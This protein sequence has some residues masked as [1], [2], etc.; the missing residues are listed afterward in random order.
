VSSPLANTAPPAGRHVLSSVPGHG[1]SDLSGAL[2]RHRQR[3]AG[4]TEPQGGYPT[5]AGNN[6]DAPAD[7]QRS[8]DEMGQPVSAYENQ[9][10]TSSTAWHPSGSDY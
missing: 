4:P 10:F 6:P 2:A 8:S 5:T 1:P 9:A 3:D 7:R